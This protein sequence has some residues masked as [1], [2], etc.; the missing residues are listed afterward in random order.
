VTDQQVEFGSAVRAAQQVFAK[1]RNREV[2]E[3]A[4]R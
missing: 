4:A 3:V 2:A 1:S